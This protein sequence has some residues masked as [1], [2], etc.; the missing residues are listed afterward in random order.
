MI[1][2]FLMAY[3]LVVVLM[4]ILS[5]FWIMSLI[6][7]PEWMKKKLPIKHKPEIPGSVNRMI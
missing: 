2:L 7:A 6:F 1:K 5:V 3:L 4:T